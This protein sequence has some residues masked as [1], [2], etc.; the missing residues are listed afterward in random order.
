MYKHIKSKIPSKKAYSETVKLTQF[1][2]TV[3]LPD[4]IDKEIRM[5]EF[6]RYLHNNRK[7]KFIAFPGTTSR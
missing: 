5:H 2:C 7:A 6:K 4:T 3:T 1:V